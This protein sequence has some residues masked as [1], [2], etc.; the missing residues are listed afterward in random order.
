MKYRLITNFFV[1]LLAVLCM[2]GFAAASLSVVCL[3]QEG[4]YSK[5]PKQ[6]YAAE[7]KNAALELAFSLA[8]HYAAVDVAHM[9][10]VA[11]DTNHVHERSSMKIQSDYRYVIRDENSNILFSTVAATDT[12]AQYSYVFDLDVNHYRLCDGEKDCFMVQYYDAETDRYT[13]C[14]YETDGMDNYIVEVYLGENA[15]PLGE[16]WSLL[17]RLYPARYVLIGVAGL[18]LL[19]GIGALVY[20]LWVAGR[21]RQ[22]QIAPGGLCKIPLDIHLVLDAFLVVLCYCFFKWL[23]QGWET[24]NI[25]PFAA[26]AVALMSAMGLGWI[27]CLAAQGKV[28][29][30]YWWRHSLCGFCLCK[31]GRFFGKCWHGLRA[32][33]AMLPVIW[34]WLIIAAAMGILLLVNGLIAVG[35]S[36]FRVNGWIMVFFATLAACI[37]MILYGGWCFGQILIGAKKKAEGQLDYRICEDGLFGAFR[38]CAVQL[39]SLSAAAE[40]AVQERMRS[41]RMKTELITN[42]SHD[43]KTPLTSIIN[44]VDLLQKPHT[45]QEQA[46]YL[47]IL[48]RQSAQMKKLIEDLTELSK[49]NSG[50]ITVNRQEL[51]IVEAVNQALG[52]FADKLAEAHLTPVFRHETTT[53]NICADGRLVWRVL[54]NLLSNAVKYAMPET[55]VYLELSRTEREVCLAL[56]NISRQAL[57][58]DAEE[59]MERFVQGDPSRKTEGSG[60]GLNIARSLMEAQGGTLEL[61]LDGDL[62]KVTLY[63]PV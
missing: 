60:L 38:T 52:E 19:M 62:F 54:S 57:T 36:Y 1:F 58:V 21:D 10:T 30:G 46:Q 12:S 23:C 11:Y 49:A 8:D 55:R 32:V 63:F 9:P 41:E 37:A 14:Y 3:S 27:Y 33:F 34:Q 56:K 29:G 48:A 40:I 43:I 53:L 35:G 45:E 13:A 31:I 42:V 25:L 17:V 2:M 59:L 15:C 47:E 7:V 22:G 4:L 18:C 61:R 44:F 24:L 39:N 5:E 28:K 51:D 26:C 20:L 16:Y 6:V 50:N